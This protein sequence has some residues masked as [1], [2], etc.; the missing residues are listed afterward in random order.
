MTTMKFKLGTLASK[1]DSAI[2]EAETDHVI[3]RIWRKDAAL[4]KTEDESQRLIKNS[5]GWLTIADEMIG[6]AGELVEYA[7][8]I[9]QRG[10]R[11]VMVCGMGGSS[12][13]PEVLRQ[14]FSHRE[15]FPELLILDSTDPDV[16]AEFAQRIDIQHCLFVI[17]SKSGSTIEPLVFNKFWF[18]ELSKQTTNPGENFIA[19]TDPGSPMT[20][21]AGQKRFEEVFHNEPDIDSQYSV[22]SYFGLVPAALTGIDIKQLLNQAKQ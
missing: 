3:K 9:R 15:G 6:V 22:L 10:F 20:E 8:M 21:M 19:I 17:S 7:E 16:I 2:H 14:T 11:Q 12:L 13:C 5:L 4:W 18:E 1:F